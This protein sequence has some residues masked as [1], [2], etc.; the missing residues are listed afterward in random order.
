MFNLFGRD[1]G[2]QFTHQWGHCA[3]DSLY[4]YQCRAM[5]E[6][7]AESLSQEAGQEIRILGLYRGE[8]EVGLSRCP[9]WNVS[10]IALLLDRNGKV[11]AEVAICGSCCAPSDVHVRL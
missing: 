2:P 9:D 8:P 3:L 1:A 4:L 5:L 10:H 6:N 11:T 7:V